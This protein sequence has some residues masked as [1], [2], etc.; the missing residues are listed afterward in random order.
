MATQTEVSPANIQKELSRIWDSL[1]TKNK[2]RASLFNLI[3]YT[4]DHMREEYLKQIAQKTIEKFPS[5]IIF[6]SV[7]RR[8]KEDFL[9]A[10]V[11]I[12]YACE[13]E[14]CDIA[15]DYIQL[16]VSS[17]QTERV[18]FVILPHL[19]P[20]LPVYLLWADDPVHEN[21][22]SEE[23]EQFATRIIFDSESTDNLISF[24]QGVLFHKQRSGCDIA[25]LNWARTDSWRKLLSSTFNHPERLIDLKDA[26]EITIR[27][28]AKASESFCHTKIQATYIQGWLASRLGWKFKELKCD[29]ENQIFSYLNK[30]DSLVTVTLTPQEHPTLAPGRIISFDLSTYGEKHYAFC[31]RDDLCNHIMIQISSKEECEMPTQFIFAKTEI[32]QSLILDICRKGTSEH[33]SDLL[34]YFT[35]TNLKEIC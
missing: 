16:N 25:D 30:D 7:D 35:H 20:D 24:A 28:N 15:C 9:K 13:D 21:P 5:R 12:L 32:G 18:P 1:E 22:L 23:L 8:T 2:M 14:I 26:K 11:S 3:I 17:T 27:Y 33:F 34:H 4:H 6:V 29:K 19:I 31:R 10:S